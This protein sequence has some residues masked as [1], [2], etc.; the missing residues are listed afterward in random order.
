MLKITGRFLGLLQV[1]V[2][3]ADR[4]GEFVEAELQLGDGQRLHC[5]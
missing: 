5:H 1:V 3:L 4:Q 2:H